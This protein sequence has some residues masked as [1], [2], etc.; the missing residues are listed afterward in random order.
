M[1]S[2]IS[3]RPTIRDLAQAANVSS[4]TVDRVLNKRSTVRD[5]TAQ[6]V[7]IAAEKIGYHAAGILKIRHKESKPIKRVVCLLQRSSDFFYQSLGLAIEQASSQLMDFQLEV[8]IVFMAEVS[9]SH[10]A[11]QLKQQAAK[12][13]AIVLVSLDHHTVNKEV[14]KIIYQ[15][16]P[17]ITLLSPLSSP[18]QSGHIGQDS[19]KVG[20]TAGWAISSLAKKSGEVAILLGSHRYLNQEIA[21]ISFISYFREFGGGFTL[22][23]PILNL[24]DD[25]LAAEATAQLL[26]DHPNLVGIYSA[27]GG[28]S[29]MISTLRSEE[30]PDNLVTICNELMP[31]T[32]DALRD[33]IVNMV[34]A[35]PVERVAQE[36]IAMLNRA[37][38][39]RGP[40]LNNT[41]Y[42]PS[43]LYI[44]ENI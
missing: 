9:P 3:K 44:S 22:L 27:G 19:R 35:T 30:T 39:A 13:D 18:V 5:A 33:G 36:A 1:D 4:A 6:R 12:A 25:R 8:S 23:P 41:I 10:I 26:A 20:R 31:A 16:K 28:V 42:V 29:G 32:R 7:L 2:F 38:L 15:G 11:E 24:D 14:E 21:E 34:I 43:E 40:V 17:V 37:F